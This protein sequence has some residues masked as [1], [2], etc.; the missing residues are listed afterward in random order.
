[1]RVLITGGSGLIGRALVNELVHHGHEPVVV[2]RDPNRLRGFVEGIETARWNAV[3]AEQLAAALEGADALVHLAGESIA[4]GRWTSER[5]ERILD[6]RVRSSRAVSEAMALLGRPPAVL[7]QGSAV[8]Y[9]GPR[10]DEEVD[11]TGSAGDDFLAR[12]CVAWEEA[13]A[14]V[15]ELGV[16]R[17]VLRTGVVLA[18]DGGA[19]SRMALPFR[20][21]AGGPVGS[22]DQ[23]LP[24]THLADEVGAI[25]FLL[26]HADARGAF[27]L[28]APQPV[29]NR[30][31][32]RVLGKVLRR[33]AFIPTPGFVLRLALGEMATLVLDGQRAVPRGLGALG[34]EFRF[35]DLESALRDLLD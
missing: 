22:G 2:S 28:V 7:L 31:L 10:G 14:A 15:E 35:R 27:N 23:W 13:S 9:Y 24:W 17:A 8:G 3:D 26:E 5:K 30:Q 18:R 29:T 4:S 25:R 21:F 11:E 12:V 6:S 34:C 19:L 16:R 32:A 1:M 33:P 20:L